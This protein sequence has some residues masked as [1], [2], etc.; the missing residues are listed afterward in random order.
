MLVLALAIIAY[1]KRRACQRASMD[2]AAAPPA[3]ALGPLPNPERLLQLVGPVP[4]PQPLPRARP[5]TLPLPTPPPSPKVHF[6]IGD[7]QDQIGDDMNHHYEE[8]P[9]EPV[10]P[11]KVTTL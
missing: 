2:L 9:E 10:Q 6:T 3:L 4:P 8:I 5:T 11:I 1:L 7:D